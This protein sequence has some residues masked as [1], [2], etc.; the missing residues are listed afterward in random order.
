MMKKEGNIC[1]LT[2][3]PL[4]HVTG[5]V[6]LLP[7]RRKFKVPKNR[8]LATSRI[9][10][11]ENRCSDG[12]KRRK[13]KNSSGNNRKKTVCRYRLAI[14]M[15]VFGTSWISRRS[16]GE[17]GAMR[18]SA[19][20]WYQTKDVGG[21]GA[22]SNPSDLVNV[23]RSVDA[24]VAP[25]VEPAMTENFI[26]VWIYRTYPSPYAPSFDGPQREIRNPWSIQLCFFCS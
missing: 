19:S 18:E 5:T 14:S 23:Q 7:P 2:L 13:R 20:S 8:D 15:E 3:F 6:K 9:A 1:W 17:A 10:R 22:A 25:A 12:R 4:I 16:S 26:R 21:G 11:F 24:D